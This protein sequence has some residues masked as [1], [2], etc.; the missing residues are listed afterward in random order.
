M[1]IKNILKG[2]ILIFE[3]FILLSFTFFN[4]NSFD[5]KVASDVKTESGHELS[6]DSK[7]VRVIHTTD[8][9]FDDKNSLVRMLLF[10]N[11]QNIIGITPSA[12][13]WQNYINNEWENIIAKINL[14]EKVY[15][16]LLKHDTEYPTPEYL[17][18]ITKRGNLVYDDFSKDTDGSML[19]ANTL[20]DESDSR[21]VWVTCWG[22][23]VT[24][25]AALRYINDNFPEKKEY[26]ANKL[27][28]YF[29]AAKYQDTPERKLLTYIVNHYDPAPEMIDNEIYTYTNG[30]GEV[31][32]W[33]NNFKYSTSQWTTTNYNR[34]HGALANSFVWKNN[35]NDD[36]DG[37]APALLHLLG[38]AFG[39]RSS[40][41]PAFGGWG[42]RFVPAVDA[43]KCHTVDV[44][45][46]EWESK[47][48]LPASHPDFYVQN[49]CYTQ[50]K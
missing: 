50:S 49:L 26:V 20:L 12:G 22:G 48:K 36:V 31:K 47:Y 41:N 9:G 1:I 37:D 33:C 16:N 34:N 18:S 21:T 45:A 39:L 42:S 13:P 3:A 29:I 30:W 15:P 25:T 23:P 10:A 28:V 2:I 11:N 4:A 43:Y 27:K 46:D 6:G 14:Y 44:N 5:K 35:Y 38:S 17:R 19:I 40:E 8:M 7:K 32:Y 24:L